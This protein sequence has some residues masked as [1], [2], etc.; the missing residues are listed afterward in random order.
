MTTQTIPTDLTWH[1]APADQ[2]QMIEIAYAADTEH[3]RVW[4][5]STDHSDG[6][7]SYGYADAADMS[8]Q[9]QP[10]NGAPDIPADSWREAR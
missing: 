2:G 6:S 1:V 10:W 9:F 5:R 3:E 8:G 7:V 4:R